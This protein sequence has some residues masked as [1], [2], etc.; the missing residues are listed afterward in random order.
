MRPARPL[1]HHDAGFTMVELLVS[2]LI[3]GVLMA[4][5]VPSYRH[6]QDAQDFV[7]G[8]RN[9]VSVLRTAQGS[10]VA[11]ETTYRVDFSVGGRSITTYR[12]NASLATPAFVKVK[13]TTLRGSS[14]TFTSPAFTKRSG[15][16]SISAYFYARGTASDGQVVIAK[17]GTSKRLTVSVEGLTGRVTYS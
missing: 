11:E 10:A 13:T 14:P 7:G 6:Y 1:R 9:T 15:G 2:M 4:L 3:A 16:T 5:A 8:A 12:W 17:S